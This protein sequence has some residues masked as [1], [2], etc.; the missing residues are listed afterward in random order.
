MYTINYK[1]LPL[2]LTLTILNAQPNVWINE[3]HYDNA[4]SDVN[5]GVEIILENAAGYTLS[6]FTLSLYNGANGARYSSLFTLDEFSE[7]TTASGFTIF[8]K[9]IS[10]IQ[11]GAPDGMALSYQ[12]TLISGQF[13]SYEG[14]IVAIDGDA[15]GETSTDIGVSES[16]A[17]LSSE[18]LQLTGNGTT[19]SEFTWGGPFS[20]TMGFSNNNNSSD[21]SLPVELTQF[22]G[23]VKDGNVDL[24]W[25]TESEINNLGYI[26]HRKHSD[27]DY[28]LISSYKTNENLKGKGSATFRSEYH[29]LDKNVRIGE[30]YTYLLTDVDT[31]GKTT[32][33]PTITIIAK[34]AGLT[35]SPSYPNPCNPSTSFDVTVGDESTI[36]IEVYTLLGRRVSMLMNKR[37]PA[38]V[39]TIHWNG[40]NNQGA[41]LA[42][43]IYFLWI[44]SEGTHEVQ[45]IVLTR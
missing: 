40:T 12:G 18:S 22:A 42:S 10:G 30:Q 37:L 6:D 11:N 2:L 43:G 25:V 14:V 15:S 36:K 24:I 34:A 35:V 23:V 29:Y 20:S 9:Y 44:Q 27:R 19:Y 28:K 16:N 32:Q 13:L 21:Q 7:G 5:E 1:A 39:Y 31:E 41:P 17:T 3:I 8:Y 45:K 26:L 33:H 4:G 38:G